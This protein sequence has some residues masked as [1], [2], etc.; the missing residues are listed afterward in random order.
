[1][2][3]TE[4]TDREEPEFLDDW[5]Q[6]YKNHLATFVAWKLPSGKFQYRCIIQEHILNEFSDEPLTFTQVED[7]FKKRQELAEYF[8]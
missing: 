2:G 3:N 7:R 1:M 5:K 6:V 8:E 4:I